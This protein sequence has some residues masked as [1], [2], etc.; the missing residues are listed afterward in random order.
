VQLYGELSAIQNLEFFASLAGRRVNREEIRAALR[1]VGLEDEAHRRR[2]KTYSKGMRQKAGLA[3]AI[4]RD[5][6][7]LLLDEPT[8]GLDPRAA[9]E[10]TR[11]LGELRDEGKAILMST[12][13]IF[14]AKQIADR[15][16]IMSQ[17][18]LLLERSRAELERED[19]EALYLAYV[20]PAITEEMT[21]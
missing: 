21:G 7:A 10:L 1:R 14:R 13:D 4:L 18:R 17:G 19:L 15:I 2:V 16:G 5:A 9:W 8:S 11:L 12:H 20:A 3:S 6:P